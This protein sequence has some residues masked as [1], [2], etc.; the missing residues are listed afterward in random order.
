MGSKHVYFKQHYEP[1]A[2]EFVDCPCMQKHVAAGIASDDS[3]DW[4]LW[5]ACNI[6][7]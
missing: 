1:L 7:P 6:I 4:I 3:I 2:M 5:M